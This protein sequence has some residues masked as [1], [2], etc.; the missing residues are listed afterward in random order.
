MMNNPW[1]KIS[2]PVPNKIH[3]KRVD[4]QHPLDIFWGRDQQ[5]RYL[6]VCLLN[7]EV[8]LSDDLPKVTGVEVISPNK[9]TLILA[10]KDTDNWELFF[11]L[12]E[13]VI[14]STKIINDSTNYLIVILRR[15]SSWQ[16]FLMRERSTIFTEEKIKGLIGELFLI[17]NHL[18]PKFGVGDSIKFWMGPEGAPQDFIVNNTVIEVKSKLGDTAGKI[19]INSIEQLCPQVPTMYLYVV[20]LG[21]AES[22]SNECIDLQMLIEEVRNSI[23]DNA[24]AQL[25]RFNDL[26]LQINYINND[27]YKNYKYLLIDESIYTVKNGFPRICQDSV[28]TGIDRISYSVLLSECKEYLTSFNWE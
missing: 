11:S 2:K 8:D 15:L 20:T 6:L 3:R 22:G 5:G 9:N 23:F 7:K 21:K 14:N 28:A 26:L 13:D 16:K 1:S 19:K 25:E 24:P 18:T 12:C 10:L 17:K 27:D 4:H